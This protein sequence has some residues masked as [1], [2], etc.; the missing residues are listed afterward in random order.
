MA[1]VS[2]VN[3][4]LSSLRKRVFREGLSCPS[5]GHAESVQVD[6]KMIVTSLRRCRNCGLLFRT[7][8]TSEEENRKFY[9][10]EYTENF[11]LVPDRAELESLLKTSFE[12]S[13]GRNY[14]ISHYIGVLSAFG[15][16][17]D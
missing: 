5:C 14:N 3:Y 9:Q 15:C 10:R 6:R 1:F 2:K 11:T 8:T 16:K 17:P 7:P 4:F 12:V 13:D